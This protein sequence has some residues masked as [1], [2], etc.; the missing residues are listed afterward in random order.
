MNEI[1]SWVLPIEY[2]D[3]IIKKAKSTGGKAGKGKNKTS[4]IQV[5]K[6]NQVLKQFKYSLFKQHKLF[7][8]I[9]KAKYYV[10]EQSVNI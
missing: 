6:N 10:I 9:G 1:C 5:V 2:K 4:T 3:F 8:A 7:S